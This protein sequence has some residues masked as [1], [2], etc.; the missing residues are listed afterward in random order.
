MNL[1]VN[2]FQ[3]RRRESRPQTVTPPSATDSQSS[4]SDGSV[5]TPDDDPDACARSSSRFAS[6]LKSASSSSK[7]PSS[8]KQKPQHPHVADVWSPQKPTVPVPPDSDDDDS[9]NY[10]DDTT[11]IEPLPLPLPLPPPPIP[12]SSPIR[13]SS[14]SPGR[15]ARALP[16]RSH[17]NLRAIT[18][19]ALNQ[20][21]PC[22]P[23]L[24]APSGPVFPRSSN[25][26]HSLPV[27]HTTHIVHLKTNLIRRLEAR[28][29]TQ[30]EHDS[31]V[32]FYNRSKHTQGV[33]ST[34]R[35]VDL[36]D[37][38]DLK[39]AK[40]V[41][42]FSYGLQRWIKRPCF[43]ERCV[44]W[45]WDSDGK[46]LVCK[47]ISGSGHAI[48]LLEFSEGLEAM[49]GFGSSPADGRISAQ[50]PPL[51]IPPVPHLDIQTTGSSNP[52]PGPATPSTP[53]RKTLRFAP[54]CLSSDDDEDN[55]P[56]GIHLSRREEQE[57]EEK[58][59]KI[60]ADEVIKARL[61]ADAVRTGVADKEYLHDRRQTY[62]RPIYDVH[63]SSGVGSVRSQQQRIAITA[64]SEVDLSEEVKKKP[65]NLRTSTWSGDVP[66]TQSTIASSDL[67]GIK[68]QRRRS[69]LS[70][71]SD[72][73]GNTLSS[74]SRPRTTFVPPSVPVVPLPMQMQ[75]HSMPVYPFQLQPMIPVPTP[76]FMQP[77]FM[78]S[79]S[80]I[81]DPLSLP[82]PH[83]IR[84]GFPVSRSAERLVPA[85]GSAYSAGK[86][87]TAARRTTA[88]PEEIRQLSE[89]MKRSGNRYEQQGRSL[90]KNSDG[91]GMDRS[92]Q[93]EGQGDRNRVHK[94]IEGTR[95]QSGKVEVSKRSSRMLSTFTLP[96]KESTTRF[97]VR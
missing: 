88:G 53:V 28:S 52:S 8:S 54:T 20:R 12:A 3:S 5:P 29:L 18:L 6:W 51:K 61:R 96:S 26:S 84:P 46:G 37:V 89:Q 74:S 23:F 32:P 50:L 78:A 86:S 92:R 14:R 19:S 81:R 38:S 31:I 34:R 44:A 45:F 59:K 85:A 66:R 21:P 69:M 75:V 47:P 64:K 22:P 7:Q 17:Q 70:S 90:E 27:V 15:S 91:R 40:R 4:S 62:S 35:R 97:A 57:R 58:K 83:P 79:S 80:P 13:P 1:L 67:E 9:D 93:V 65:S 76:V 68:A 16:D 87:T 60:I 95:S 41:H 55:I 82:L 43:E 25:P 42:D 48:A 30:A 33:L 77:R 24:H 63:A 72:V 71:T 94:P 11:I 10:G 56:L 49:A 2:V 39:D 36:E 73:E